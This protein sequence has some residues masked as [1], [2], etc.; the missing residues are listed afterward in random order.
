MWEALSPLPGVDYSFVAT[1]ERG[2]SVFESDGPEA[3]RIHFVEANGIRAGGDVPSQLHIT[4]C[5]EMKKTGTSDLDTA[6]S[7]SK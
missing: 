6:L 2:R 1:Y 4:W 3:A 5:D 7:V